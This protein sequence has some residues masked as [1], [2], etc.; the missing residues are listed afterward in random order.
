MGKNARLRR[1]FAGS[2][3]AEEGQHRGDVEDI[4]IF[5]EEARQVTTLQP[6]DYVSISRLL[7]DGERWWAPRT[8]KGLGYDA[9]RGEPG[10]IGG[11]GEEATGWAKLGRTP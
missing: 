10:T 6:V 1:S 5:Y 8:A 7:G 3:E 2:G 9:Q 11:V 4:E